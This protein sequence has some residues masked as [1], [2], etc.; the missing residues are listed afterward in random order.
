MDQEL[1]ILKDDLAGFSSRGPAFVTLGETMVRDMPADNQRPEAARQVWISMAGSELTLAVA[2]SRLGVPSSY[3]TRVP[4]NPYGWM[5]RNIARQQ[6]LDTTHIIWADRT[7]LIGRFIYEIG[8]SPRPGAVWYQRKHSAASK[9]GA[10]MVDWSA[11]LKDARLLH[12]S[13]ITFALSSHSG[14]DRN[15]LLEAFQEALQAKPPGC[16]IG[17]DFNYRGTLWSAAQCK[18]T[19]TP[20]LNEHVD[21]LITSIEDMAKVYGMSCGRVSAGEI[22]RGDIGRI[23]DQDVKALLAELLKRFRLTVAA[24]TIR[25][26]DTHEQHRWESVAMDREGHFFRSPAVRSIV[27]QDRLGGGDTWNGGFYYGLLT[28]P[29]AER[30]LAKGVLVGDAFTRLKQTLMFD[31]PIVTKEEVQA[32]LRADASGGGKRT[33]R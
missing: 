29:D 12:T 22:E 20:L 13:G 16:L 14:Y 30:A 19:M 21:I 18:G 24:V 31:L 15:Y 1:N 6:G 4:D 11:A 9:L 2:L 23:K 8:K 5:L 17:L 28:E 26:P 32:L 25:Y 3:I 33:T 10:G 7:E 27:L